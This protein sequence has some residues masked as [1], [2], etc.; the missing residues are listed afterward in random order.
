MRGLITGILI[1]IVVAASV[2]GTVLHVP[3]EYATI[4]EAIDSVSSPYDTI[5][6]A[7]GTYTGEGFTKLIRTTSWYGWIISSAGPDQTIIDLGGEW[8]YKSALNMRGLTLRNGSTALE[9]SYLYVHETVFENNVIA[10]SSDGA[11]PDLYAKECLFVDNDTA[12][13]TS[14][15]GTWYEHVLFG[16]VFLNNEEVFLIDPIAESLLKVGS[17]VLAFN[18][19]CTDTVYYLAVGNAYYKNGSVGEGGWAVR[20]LF[21]G[22][23]DSLPQ[24][25]ESGDREASTIIYADPLFCDT[26]LATGVDVSIYSPLLP[27]NSEC[28]DVIGNVSVGCDCGDADM[29]SHINVAD[30]AYLVAYLFH[31]GP[32]PAPIEA[33]EEDGLQGVNVADITYLVAY[34]FQGGPAPLC[35]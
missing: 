4:Q 6:L 14:A 7:P 3:S 17:S 20:N 8:F 22:N 25:A 19:V 10:I 23:G 33:G 26:S 27:A 30:L 9:S 34:L 29:S 24:T 1:V 28:T 2:S 12:V 21:W 15:E 13:I 16:C 31:G 11:W 18:A 35:P 5:M 32:A